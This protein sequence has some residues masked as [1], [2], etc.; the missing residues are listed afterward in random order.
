MRWPCYTALDPNWRDVY[1]YLRESTVDDEAIWPVHTSGLF[2]DA[3][4]AVRR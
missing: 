3:S 1:Y 2:D 4:T